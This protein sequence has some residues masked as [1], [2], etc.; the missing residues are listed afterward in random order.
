MFIGGLRPDDSTRVNRRPVDGQ[1]VEAA[2]P[3]ARLPPRLVLCEG[4]G[5]GVLHHVGDG[6]SRIDRS[7]VSGA[8]VSSLLQALREFFKLALPFVAFFRHPF[9]ADL[10]RLE[11]SVLFNRGAGDRSETLHETQEAT[12][13]I[14]V[15]GS[16]TGDSSAQR[17]RF[18]QRNI[19]ARVADWMEPIATTAE[20][21]G[22][23]RGHAGKWYLAIEEAP[24]P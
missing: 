2:G 13:I 21:K 3:P 16:R 1:A 6:G 7:G 8:A 11:I 17:A 18:C 9:V 20:E 23:L 14:R 19:A 10:E 12:E 22:F 5:R 24:Q 4:R 15:T